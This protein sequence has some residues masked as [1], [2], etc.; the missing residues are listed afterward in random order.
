M[1]SPLK[2]LLLVFAAIAVLVVGG[3][4]FYV[5]GGRAR[6]ER[7]AGF[8]LW[9]DARQELN[10]YLTIWPGDHAARL[11]L[12]EAWYRDESLPGEEAL[13][14]A[15]EELA[16]IPDDCHE[17]PVAR[18]QQG[19]IELLMRHRPWRAE[20]YL[21]RSLELAP[22]LVDSNFLMWKLYDLTGRSQQAEPYFWKVHDRAP[23]GL[24]RAERLREWY[25]SQFY[26]A[27]ANPMLERLM[28]LPP[29][30][31]SPLVGEARRFKEFRDS[32]PDRPIGH[33][34]LALAFQADGDLKTAMKLLE[35]GAEEIKEDDD[36]PFYLSVL[37]NVAFG[38]GDFPKAEE[39]FD[40]WP[41]PHAGHDYWY[42]RALVMHQ[43][44]GEYE[45]ARQC[46]L[47]LLK[48]WPGPVEWRVYN[49]LADCLARL[50]QPDEAAKVRARAKEIENL[51]S[52]EVLGKLRDSLGHLDEPK[53]AQELADFYRKI[54]RPREAAAWDSHVNWLKSRDVG[55]TE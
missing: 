18:A 23:E 41:P 17:G 36:H 31:T 45:D 38:L 13:D 22:D 21:Q 34:A 37:V 9:P 25:M 1:T 32:E 44:R 6:A 16:A 10:R 3:G 46:Y 55:L 30:P 29:D 35:Q 39:A 5:H 47:S 43:I 27:T 12:A 52:E 50:K 26:P 8:E 20:Q 4:M 49:R 53:R 54:D 11:L 7:M 15:M 33:A 28:G 14:A 2:Q 19:R 51:M 42:A 48:E 24:G 40:K